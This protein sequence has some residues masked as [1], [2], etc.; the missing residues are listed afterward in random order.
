MDVDRLLNLERRTGIKDEEI[1][2]FT[3]KADAVQKAI[4]AMMRGEIK[5][6]DIKIDGIDT[7]EE[8]RQKEVRRLLQPLQ[9]AIQTNG[10]PSFSPTTD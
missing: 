4:Q 10:P 2:E 3:T 9:H 7:D 6:E 5:P 1:D 8:I